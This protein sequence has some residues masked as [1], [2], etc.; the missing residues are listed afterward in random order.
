MQLWQIFTLLAHCTRRLA[1]V[2]TM[3]RVVLAWLT[4]VILNSAVLLLPVSVGHALLFAIPQLPVGLKSNGKQQ[5]RDDRWTFFFAM[6]VKS[7]VLPGLTR[8][9]LFLVDLFSI[10]VGLCIIST[11]IAACRDLSTRVISGKTRLLALQRHLLVC[12]WVRN[13]NYSFTYSSVSG[14]S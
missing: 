11:I 6:E 7:F 14:Y 12:I 1:A 13:L 10:T 9:T 5:F 8:A 4:A 3:P 2:L